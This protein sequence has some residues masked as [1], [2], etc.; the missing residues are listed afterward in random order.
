MSSGTLIFSGQYTAER[1]RSASSLRWVACSLK[2]NQAKLHRL[3]S[4]STIGAVIVN[5]FTSIIGKSRKTSR[6]L[7][8]GYYLSYLDSSGNLVAR[9]N[10]NAVLIA[11]ESHLGRGCA[12]TLGGSGYL[13][14]PANDPPHFRSH[15]WK[16]KDTEGKIF[17]RD[18]AR[19]PAT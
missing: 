4:L 9:D 8:E 6:R 17:E 3:L 13:E 14:W 2:P 5:Y 10:R 18:Q 11:P 12:V 16:P 7:G 1:S 19:H 15:P